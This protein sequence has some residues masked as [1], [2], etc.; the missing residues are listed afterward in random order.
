MANHGKDI[1]IG[2]GLGELF[3]GMSRM[4]VKK[5]LGDPHEIEIYDYTEG[6]KA[7]SWHYDAEEI[8][9]TF[10]EEEADWQL[11]TLAISSDI[12]T[13][14]GASFVGLSKDAAIAKIKELDLGAYEVEKV[15]NEPDQSL[16]HLLNHNMY[17]WLDADEV[18]EIQ[19]EP[20]W[21]E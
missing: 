3:F 1:I 9:L 12:Y 11:E 7:E 2:R 14:E 6:E 15:E 19:W 5:V 8:S 4:D 21:E 20:L 17:F 18:A 13:L 16:I 10:F